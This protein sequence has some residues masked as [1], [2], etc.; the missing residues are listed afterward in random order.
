MRFAD[1][2]GRA[3]IKRRAKVAAQQ[4]TVQFGRLRPQAGPF[5]D[6]VRG[7]LAEKDTPGFRVDPVA[8]DD[9]GFSQRQPAVGAGLGMERV[10]RRTVDTI[11]S[12]VACLSPAGRQLADPAEPAFA[13]RQANLL[14]ADVTEGTCHAECCRL[15]L[16]QV[17]AERMASGVKQ[18]DAFVLGLVFSQRRAE[19][20]CGGDGCIDVVDRD[21]DVHHHQLLTGFGGPY[22]P[23]VFRG[24][25]EADERVRFPGLDGG[26]VL[27]PLDDRPAEHG[28]VEVG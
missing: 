10:R 8:V 1:V 21:V 5:I 22:R 27:I 11:R 14:R 15:F 16:V 24:F 25:L 12:L 6:P 2:S 28:G 4:V 26:A 20:P 17:Q 19:F 9:L 18:Y 13:G 23:D 3:A 7:V